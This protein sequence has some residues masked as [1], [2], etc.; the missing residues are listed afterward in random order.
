MNKTDL[1]EGKIHSQNYEGKNLN[2]LNVSTYLSNNNFS[3]SIEICESSVPVIE[4]AR[5][6][7][8]ELHSHTNYFCDNEEY[9]INT[10]QNFANKKPKSGQY[11]SLDNIA[12]KT[13]N[14]T[15]VESERQDTSLSLRQDDNISK[16]S[17]RQ[18]IKSNIKE[19]TQEGDLTFTNS[20]S[21]NDL[22][23]RGDATMNYLRSRFQKTTSYDH[24]RGLSS[25]RGLSSPLGSSSISNNTDKLLKDIRSKRLRAS[26]AAQSVSD[27]LV[28]SVFKREKSVPRNDQK[29]SYL[30]QDPDQPSLLSNPRVSYSSKP[31]PYPSSDVINATDI[32][33]S[34][35]N[36]S[37]PKLYGNDASLHKPP[38]S[39]DNSNAIRPFWSTQPDETLNDSSWTCTPRASTSLNFERKETP[40]SKYLVDKYL[41]NEKEKKSQLS[42]TSDKKYND[43][44]S[45]Q[46]YC[47]T[48]EEASKAHVTPPASNLVEECSVSVKL[49]LNPNSSQKTDVPQSSDMDNTEQKANN[50]GGDTI[51]GP[52][53][54][55][56]KSSSISTEVSNHR[57]RRPEHRTESCDPSTSINGSSR[58]R[59][60]QDD[61]RSSNSQPSSKKTGGDSKPSSFRRRRRQEDDEVSDDSNP[62]T[63]RNYER[64]KKKSFDEQ[65]KSAQLSNTS[66]SSNS[67]LVPQVKSMSGSAEQQLDEADN[68]NDQEKHEKAPEKQKHIESNQNRTE[69]T[70]DIP[71]ML[72]CIEIKSAAQWKAM[73]D[74]MSLN[75]ESVKEP[76][77]EEI[78]DVKKLEGKD[79]AHKT[80]IVV[81]PPEDDTKREI[82][83]KLPPWDTTIDPDGFT[84]VEAKQLR[85]I[86][87][88]VKPWKENKSRRLFSSQFGEQWGVDCDEVFQGLFIGDK[89]SASNIKFLKRYGI[90]HVLNT[91]EGKDEGLVDLS[92]EYFEGSGINY[93]GF[94][95]WDHPNCNLIPYFGCASEYIEDAIL[96]GGK[97]LVNCQMGVSRSASC[98]MS[99]M[100]I[101][102]GM[103]V[104]EALTL[105]RKS[106]DTRPN[107][108]MYQN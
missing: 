11:F 98:A 38:S 29:S 59:R 68:K 60:R 107:D 30:S 33:S 94:P 7:S 47:E 45:H 18:E 86:C 51:A 6:D 41:Q 85:L 32:H 89:A 95:L 103:C 15:L 3:S 66:Q 52:P 22:D 65:E 37:I 93:L 27:N 21:L 61:I 91:A 99:Y 39:S 53:A 56:E 2:D 40:K 70:N 42:N 9:R 35:I 102:E 108:G 88:R 34:P 78:T 77:E 12:D 81:K 43:T 96:S 100:M 50:V 54:I 55:C 82:T 71:E 57:R 16:L 75:F 62:F 10:F 58:R 73:S 48:N 105:F 49:V 24:E 74:L 25:S 26:N 87:W 14:N 23:G 92:P 69:S 63:K 19:Y 17:D 64:E 79:V 90:T 44:S 67:D 28:S 1:K 84:R 4:G 20:Q 8:V 106:R 13:D 101:K 97:C 31:I 104:K 72:N 80:P 83:Y 46:A 76:D 36:Y 5:K